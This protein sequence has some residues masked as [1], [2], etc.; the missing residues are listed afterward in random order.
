MEGSQR[1]ARGGVGV[2]DSRINVLKATTPS[3]PC[4]KMPKLCMSAPLSQ[5][6]GPEATVEGGLPVSPRLEFPAGL[7]MAA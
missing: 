4:R 7:C 6:P 3:S 1:R 2:R 5:R